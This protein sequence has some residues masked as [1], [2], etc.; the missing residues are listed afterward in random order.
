VLCITGFALENIVDDGLQIQ[1]G[2]S[3]S[4]L[5]ILNTVEVSVQRCSGF[6]RFGGAE[7]DL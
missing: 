2:G 5:A 7:I 6:N 3:G 1:L 4:F